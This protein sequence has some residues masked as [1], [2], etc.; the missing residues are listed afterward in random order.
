MGLMDF[1]KKVGSALLEEAQKKQER[2]A[3]L[4]ER[5]ERFDD[6]SLKAKFTSSSGEEKLAI[7]LVLRDRGYGQ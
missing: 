4:K 6:N 1:A 7:G 5:Y 3:R 2:I